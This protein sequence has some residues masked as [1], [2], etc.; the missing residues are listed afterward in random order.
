MSK[1]YAKTPWKR[2]GTHIED[3]DGNYVASCFT[4][5]YPELRHLIDGNLDLIVASVNGSP[6][7]QWPDSLRDE[8][9]ALRAELKARTV[10][11]EAEA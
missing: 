9:D 3:A 6:L 10:A 11:A 7:L 5:L 4:A 2:V 1:Q 8:N